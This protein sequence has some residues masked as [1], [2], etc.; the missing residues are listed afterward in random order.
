VRPLIEIQQD[1]RLDYE[2]ALGE[3]E[4]EKE[5]SELKHSAWREEFKKHTSTAKQFL[6]GQTLQRLPR[7]CVGS[8]SMTPP[9]KLSIKR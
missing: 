8:S 6:S 5:E 9:S 2:F 7:F 1:W 4:R 3:H